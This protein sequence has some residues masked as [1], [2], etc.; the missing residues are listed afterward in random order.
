MYTIRRAAEQARPERLA[1]RLWQ[2]TN[3]LLSAIGRQNL[4][5]RKFDS[6]LEIVRRRHTFW[7]HESHQT[8]AENSSK[9]ALF[10]TNIRFFVSPQK[11]ELLGVSRSVSSA[12]ATKPPNSVAFQRFSN[13]RD[14]IPAPQFLDP[15]YIRATQLQ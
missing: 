11:T 15:N 10:K 1:N 3:S 5:Q 6:C 14:K 9:N 13:I 4:R 7:R 2:P 8:A 12:A